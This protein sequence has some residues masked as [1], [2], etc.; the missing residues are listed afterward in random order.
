LAQFGGCDDDN[1]SSWSFAINSA[2][3]TLL[4]EFD[5]HDT[6]DGNRSALSL[7]TAA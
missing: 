3:A 2:A 4:L 1:V 6:D 7:M 5:S